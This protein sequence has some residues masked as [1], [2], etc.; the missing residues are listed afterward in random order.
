MTQSQNFPENIIVGPDPAALGRDA[1]IAATPDGPMSRCRPYL[2]TVR[3]ISS[4]AIASRIGWRV[5]FPSSCGACHEPAGAAD[6]ASCRTAFV[7]ARAPG[8]VF[9]HPANGGFRTPA[10]AAIFRRLGVRPGA[11][12]LL[13]WHASKSFALELK[14][15]RRPRDASSAAIP[16]RHGACRRLR[17][18]CSRT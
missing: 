14:G 18:Y 4:T 6:L 16:V 8:L 1:S 13:L 17:R 9:L 11:S 2:S 10:E 15:R 7:L 12:D 5:R 3:N